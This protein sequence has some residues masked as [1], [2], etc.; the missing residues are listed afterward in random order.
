MQIGHPIK[1]M[2]FLLF[3]NNYSNAQKFIINKI[4]SDRTIKL[5]YNSETTSYT[6]LDDKRK[7][8]MVQSI[9]TILT[10]LNVKEDN[11]KEIINFICNIYTANKDDHENK[12]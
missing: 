8:D 10:F 6:Y 7:K 2:H 11:K 1:K 4:L 3:E 5:F 9:D 12:N